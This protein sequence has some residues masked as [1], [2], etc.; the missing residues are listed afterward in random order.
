MAFKPYVPFGMI[1]FED[2]LKMT[3]LQAINYGISVLGM[4][5]N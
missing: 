4:T 3:P 2:G 5:I 1:T